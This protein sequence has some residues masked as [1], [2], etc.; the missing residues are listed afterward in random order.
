MNTGRPGQPFKPGDYRQGANVVRLEP[1]GKVIVKPGDT[2]SKY[3]LVMY[4]NA[5]IG[6]NDFGRLENGKAQPQ[7]LKNANMI[8]AGETLIHIPSYSAANAHPHKPQVKSLYNLERWRA[9]IEKKSDE[10]RLKEGEK[11]RNEWLQFV[12]AVAKDATLVGTLTSKFVDGAEAVDRLFAYWRALRLLRLP[13]TDM[14][15][16]LPYFLKLR[17]DKFVDALKV[18]GKVGKVLQVASST[19]EA[20]VIVATAAEVS[21]L[22]DQGKYAPAARVLGTNLTGLMFKGLGVI[23]G[24]QELAEQFGPDSLKHH[25]FWKLARSFDIA[26]LMG[27]GLD[28]AVSLIEAML[29]SKGR[30]ERLDALEQRLATG[31]TR[32][33]YEIG[34][35]KAR[36]EAPRLVAYFDQMSEDELKRLQSSDGQMFLGWLKWTLWKEPMTDPDPVR[37]HRG[38]NT[39]DGFK[40]R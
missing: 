13:P 30:Q 38:G 28:A 14:L 39:S 18:G 37:R 6:W 40:T 7:P 1:G 9:F 32:V 3:A 2:I 16:V 11:A 34:E 31:P 33:F 29:V 21:S 24:V 4:G 12:E 15:K 25:R 10:I 5:H 20:V 22:L 17:K 36:S 27:A 26:A 19:A 35:H 8:L 23:N